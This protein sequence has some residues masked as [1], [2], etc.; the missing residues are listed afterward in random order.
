MNLFDR[1]DRSDSTPKLAIESRFDFLN[2]SSREE[3]D[4]VR[5]LLERLVGNHPE[6]KEMISR[7]RSGDDRHFRSAEFE[8]FLFESLRSRGFEVE[9]HPAMPNGVTTQPDFRVTTPTGEAFYLEAV[10]ASEDSDDSTE[11]PLVATTL[12]VFTTHSHENFCLMVRTSG[13]PRTQPSRK[14]LINATLAWLDGLD[15]DRVQDLISGTGYESRPEFVWQHEDFKVFL[16]AVPLEESLRG[17]SERLLAVQF[18]QPG[19]VDSWSAIRDAITFKGRRYGTLDAPLIIAVNCVNRHLSRIDE[20]QALFGQEQFSIS[21]SDPDA[22]PVLSRAP[23]GAWLGRNGPQL[24]RVSGAW[25]FS[26]LS[27]YSVARAA[28]TLYLN[29]WAAHP[30]PSEMKS[31]SYAA[32]ADGRMS[33]HAMERFSQSMNISESWLS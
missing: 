5:S 6:S 21:T 28:P 27:T 10:V 29:P 19:P 22:E 17:R 12:D 2:R 8:L 4:E 32:A 20:M 24:T 25:I 30:I 1:V 13:V 18:G 23:N 7:F 15:P 14:K 9:S 31:Y 33:W 3:I 11:H 26:N 16:S